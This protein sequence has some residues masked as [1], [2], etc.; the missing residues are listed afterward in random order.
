L[1]GGSKDGPARLWPILRDAAKRPLLRD[2][3]DRR[4]RLVKVNMPLAFYRS[5]SAGGRA[6]AAALRTGGKRH[7]DRAV[8][9][10]VQRDELADQ[11]L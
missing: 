11:Q 6:P 9:S 4:V 10:Q 5:T 8:A 7:V 2:E 1:R 3:G